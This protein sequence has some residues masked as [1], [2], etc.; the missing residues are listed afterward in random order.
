MPIPIT[1]DLISDKAA[2]A[3]LQDRRANE[4]RAL[5]PGVISET[6]PQ[7]GIGS[8]QAFDMFPDPVDSHKATPEHAVGSDDEIRALAVSMGALANG[9]ARN[10]AQKN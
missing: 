7:D 3:H 9:S 1:K 10:T 5:A 2:L 4:L 6:N 8:Q